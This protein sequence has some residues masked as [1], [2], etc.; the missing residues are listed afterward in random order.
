MASAQQIQGDG[1]LLP[2]TTRAPLPPLATPPAQGPKL[3]NSPQIPPSKPA[4]LIPISE[5]PIPEPS[6]G[7]THA[8]KHPQNPPTAPDRQKHHPPPWLINTP[9][10]LTR[11]G[12]GDAGGRRRP[13]AL[14]GAPGAGSGPEASPLASSPPTCPPPTPNSAGQ[15][16][17]GSPHR[18]PPSPHLRGRPPG[19]PAAGSLSY[20]PP[21]GGALPAPPRGALGVVVPPPARC[22]VAQ[23]AGS[24]RRTTSPSRPRAT[25][26]LCPPPRR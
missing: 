1:H 18:P 19:A 16:P 14:R 22:A 24:P 10:Q 26:Y 20:P 12:R 4:Q 21:S 2:V 25:P 9:P 11:R 6:R 5:P 17:R 23:R 7:F 15:S 13:A 8:N 3:P